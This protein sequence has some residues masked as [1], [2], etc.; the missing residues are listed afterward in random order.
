VNSRESLLDE[1]MV[2]ILCT[3]RVTDNNRLYIL[4][5]YIDAL[6]AVN[7]DAYICSYGNDT[8]EAASIF[9][10]LLVTGGGD[11]NPDLYHAARERQLILNLTL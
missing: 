11:V 3:S 2:K 6:K 7:A 5:S 1:F 10:G 4:Q 9:D 8:D